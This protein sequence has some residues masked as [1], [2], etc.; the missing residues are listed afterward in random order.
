MRIKDKNLPAAAALRHLFLATS[1]LAAS[2]SWAQ[3]AP[4]TTTA[5]ATATAR[6]PVRF[7]S[8]L[9]TVERQNI[10]LSAQQETIRGAQAEISIAGVRPDPVLKYGRGSIETS[11]AVSPKPPRTHEFE[12][13]IPIELGGKRGARIRAAESNLRLTEAN[14]QGFKRTLYQESATAFVEACR[15]REALARQESTLSAL[16]N[17]VR[18]NEI[19]RKAGDI[20][21]LEL[22]QSR[23]ERDR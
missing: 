2:A 22:S 4:A 11:R 17:V 6:A 19:R 20:G 13:E 5:T 23:V 18:A 1:L 8:F 12:I 21:G 15:S 16:S 9:D 3:D 10:G 14:L 7:S